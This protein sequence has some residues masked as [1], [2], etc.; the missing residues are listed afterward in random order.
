MNVLFLFVFIIMLKLVLNVGRYILTLYYYRKFKKHDINILK[1]SASV[2]I[3][4]DTAKTQQLVLMSDRRCSYR[5]RI[6]NVLDDSENFFMIDRVF[7]RTLGVFRTRILQ[8]VN[9]FYWIFL[10]SHIFFSLGI[11]INNVLLS[12]SNI[13]F[14]FLSAVAG[15]FLEIF[16]ESHI[17]QSV[18]DIIHNI[19]K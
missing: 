2:G 3:L 10:P 16:L 6:S 8:S 7:Q 4:F 5:D 9:P 11:S 12:I 18:T 17:P 14:W 19:L 15:Y 13:L 1:Y